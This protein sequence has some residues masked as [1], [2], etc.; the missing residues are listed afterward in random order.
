MSPLLLLL[1]MLAAAPPASDERAQERER[2]VL[3]TANLAVV[4][5]GGAVRRIDRNILDAMRL[6]PRHLL[7]PQAVRADAYRNV[8]LP[9]GHQA[10]ISQPAVVALMTQLL[11]PEADHVVL[12]VGTGSGYQA[13]ILSRLVRQV[14]SIEIVAPLAERAAQDL[15]AQRHH[16]RRRRL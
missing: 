14:Y 1:V 8:A 3:S 16:T 5:G 9:I 4:G 6:V 10:T 7:V 13:A 2:M 15:A 12:E 11:E